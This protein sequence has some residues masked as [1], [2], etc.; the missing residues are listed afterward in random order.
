MSNF[1]I[2][3]SGFNAAQTALDIIG[4]NIAN[5]ATEGYHRQRIDLTPAFSS[6]AHGVVLAGGVDVEG[7]TRMIDNLLEQEILRERSLL[8][9][10]TQEYGTLRT[11]ESALGELTAESSGLNYA[12][13]EFFNAWSKLSEY[14]GE[15]NW[16]SQVI[17]AAETMTSKFRMLGDFLSELQTQIRL[18]ADNTIDYI[19]TLTSQIASLND[20]IQ[21]M[22]VGGSD[23]NNLRDQRDQCITELSKLIEVETQ[24]RDY[25]VVN[26]VAGGI[27]VVVR[28]QTTELETGILDD[29]SYGI[30]IVGAFN[31]TT[32]VGGGK[33]GALLSLKNELVSDIQTNLDSLASA[34]VQQ[35]N[36]YHVQG[37]GSAGS[38][39]ELTG[40]VMP[41]QNLSDFIQ[42]VTDGSIYIRVTNTSTGQI[43]RNEITIDASTDTLSSIAT[44]ISGVTGLSASVVNSKLD[45]TADTDYEFDFLPAVL[46]EPEAVDI[47]FNGTTDPTVTTSGVYKG[48]SNEIL[49]FTVSCSGTVPYEIGV[50]TLTL[51]VTGSVSGAIGSYNIGLGYEAEKDI[52]IGDTGIKISLTRGDLADGDSFSIDVFSDTDTSGVLSAVGI[53]TFFLG[54]SVSDIAVCSEI[55]STPGRVA[56]FLGADMTDN[57][58]ASRIAGLKDQTISTLNNKTPGE[59]YRQL[60]TNLG[61]QLNVKKMTMENMDIIVHNLLNQQTEVSGV[62]INEEAAQMLIFEQM[63][64][65]M[66]KYINTLQV[67]I[68]SLMDVI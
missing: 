42:P 14:P 66:A 28:A 60:V 55:A 44:A 15:F 17:S 10:T 33:L 13:D 6:Y 19:N 18:E 48:A 45:I 5:A 59:F 46:P 54:N 11:I 53:N 47:N 49:T 4:N 41:S 56:T 30:S 37:V 57:E 34:M 52:D 24:S 43:T 12:I 40:W 67:S 51:T 1:E 64:Q 2:G 8:A 22:E 26:I 63:F 3:L 68:Q 27:P 50:D 65:A 9:Q 31:F 62:D 32:N 20:K 35:I 58:N 25:G 39:T 23:A 38:F 36:Q 61:Q 7:I 29:G 21:R 16:Q